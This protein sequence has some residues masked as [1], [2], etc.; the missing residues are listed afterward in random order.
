MGGIRLIEKTCTR[1]SINYLGIHNQQLCADCKLVGFDRICK[2]CNNSFIAKYRYTEHCN[3][4]KK[5]LIWKK[6]KFPER[7]KLISKAKK[8]FFQ[9]E[10]GKIIAASV[11]KI[12]SEKMKTYLL[13]DVGKKSLKDRGD[14]ISS[15]MKQK[16]ADG[17]FTPKI[18]NSFTHWDAIID[19]GNDIKKFRSSWEACIWFSNQH[20]EYEKIR[21]Q[22]I[23][24][25]S[26]PHTYIV[27][28]FDPVNNILYEIKP[29]CHV[30]SNILKVAAAEKFCKENNLQF[31]L[32]SESELLYY[33]TP[34]IFQGENKKQLNKCL[35]QITTGYMLKN[36]DHRH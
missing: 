22:Y 25:D 1:C 31:I 13:T 24:E 8:D 20:W 11:G 32:I 23:G 34:E 30:K 18:T 27:D 14:K 19:T 10:K 29:K 17:L 35:K 16:I 12:N 2:F 28:F 36:T 21:I 3:E 15:I 5:S 4:C 6:G 9:S 26:K 7:G 33:I